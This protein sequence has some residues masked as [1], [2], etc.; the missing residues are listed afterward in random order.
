MP[1]WPRH[2]AQPPRR[3]SLLSPALAVP[4]ALTPLPRHRGRAQRGLGFAAERCQGPWHH[5]GTAGWPTGSALSPCPTT[6]S[7]QHRGDAVQSHLGIC[8]K[9]LHG[10][11]VGTSLPGPWDAPAPDHKCLKSMLSCT[12]LAANGCAVVISS[13]AV[14]QLT[15]CLPRKVSSMGH[16]R[17]GRPRHCMATTAAHW[18]P[19]STAGPPQNPPGMPKGCTGGRGC[20]VGKG[21]SCDGG[22]HPSTG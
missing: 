7:R 18:V 4:A 19:A 6:S 10:P 17:Y 2:C 21:L 11:S 8:P 3:S 16:A 22:F 13:S 15:S 20:G 5:R 1:P 12:L 14:L 9:L